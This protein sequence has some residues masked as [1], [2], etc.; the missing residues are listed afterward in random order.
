MIK[1]QTLLW[2]T[3]EGNRRLRVRVRFFYFILNLPP[4]TRDVTCSRLYLDR[5][6]MRQQ[7]QMNALFWRQAV[8]SSFND[9]IALFVGLNR[10]IESEVNLNVT[11]L[12]FF[13]VVVFLIS[14]GE[15]GGGFVWNWT[16]TVK[17]V[18]EFPM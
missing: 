17:G 3:I 16:S 11:W 4:L 1:T 13:V 2:K 15:K 5:K 14:F 12:V 6:N 10:R 7:C 18:E 9:T 8:K